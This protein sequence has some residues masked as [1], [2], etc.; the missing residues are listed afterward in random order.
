MKKLVIFIGVFIIGFTALFAQNNPKIKTLKLADSLYLIKA[1][2]VN[3]VV[4]YGPDGMLL[5]DDNVEGNAK[6]LFDEIHSISKDKLKY[7]VNT[8]WHFDHTE[9]NIVLGKGVTI[10]AHEEV[11]KLL[12][13]DEILLGEIH[14]AYPDYALPSAT[15]SDKYSLNLNGETVDILS[16]S[17]GHSAGDA[18]VYFKNAN[19]LHVGDIVFADMFS[20]V[21]T[22]H[23]GNIIKLSENI[24]KIMDI[25]PADVRIIP[26]HG[27]VL[28]INDLKEYR[29]M[30]LG[31]TEIIRNEMSQNKS[32]DEIKSAKPLKA[33]NDWQVAFSC[34]DWIEFIYKSLK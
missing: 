14:K 31:T 2:G 25:Y 28:S 23:G 26:G 12:S 8:H 1:A 29:E 11:K 20:F 34:E 5:V 30:I 10:I 24:Q 22:E 3:S 7:I 13:R 15:F 21:D 16:L 32:L 27:R 9:G 18:I 19:V 33:Y 4:L 6:P 17:G